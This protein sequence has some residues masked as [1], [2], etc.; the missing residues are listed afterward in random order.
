M[1]AM[2]TSFAISDSFAYEVYLEKLAPRAV[3]AVGLAKLPYPMWRMPGWHRQSV[4]LFSDDGC[5]FYEDSYGGKSYAPAFKPGDTIRLQ[6]NKDIG[7]VS[8]Y[9]NG[10]DLGRAF[11]GILMDK[12]PIFGCI[13][14]RGQVTLNVK[15]LDK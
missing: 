10:K 15:V 4:G 6:F 14:I 11:T 2:H 9:L 7:A 13:G 12:H 8:Y 3:V 1:L 5:K